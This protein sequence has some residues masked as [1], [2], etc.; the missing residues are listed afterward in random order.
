[1]ELP[2]DVKGETFVTRKDF[3]CFLHVFIKTK[4]DGVELS[5]IDYHGASAVN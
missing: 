2:R 3:L 5:P 1:M 4:Q